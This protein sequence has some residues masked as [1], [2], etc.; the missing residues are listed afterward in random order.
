MEQLPAPPLPTPDLMRRLVGA[1]RTC[2]LDWVR[3]M[4]AEPGNPF[5]IAAEAFG[6]ATALACRA[7]PAQIWNRV[8]GLT[9]AEAALVPSIL[10]FY[11]EHG[12]DVLFDVPP[13]SVSPFWEGP[14]VLLTLARHGLYQG[15]FHQILYAAPRTDVPHPPPNVGIEEVGPERASDFVGLYEQVWGDGGAIRVLLGRPR[16]RSYIATVDGEPAALGVL[17]VADGVGSMAS[18]LT[19]PA[20]RG[21]GCQ[22]ALLHRRIRDAAGA[23]CDLLASQCRPGTASG[24]RCGLVFGLPAPRRGG[25]GHRHR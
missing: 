25:S 14:N 21:R 16:F 11:R 15:A 23:G 17:H 7:I 22:T 4:E 2:Y 18:A 6:G 3:A 13:T 5:G 9:E 1:E 19:A 20:F 8:F 10:A 24:T 12:A